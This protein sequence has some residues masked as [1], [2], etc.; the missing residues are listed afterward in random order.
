MSDS[1]I[2]FAVLCGTGIIAV[3]WFFAELALGMK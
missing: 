2:L 1:P 3:L